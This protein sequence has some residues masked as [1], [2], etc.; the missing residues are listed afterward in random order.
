MRAPSWIEDILQAA[1]DEIQPKGPAEAR[2]G[3]L[4]QARFAPPYSGAP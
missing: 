2:K 4:A 1:A 3:A